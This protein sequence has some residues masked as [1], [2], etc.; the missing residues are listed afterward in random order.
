MVEELAEVYLAADSH[1]AVVADDLKH[2]KLG[3]VQTE[4]TNSDF[5]ISSERAVGRSREPAKGEPLQ[6]S[7]PLVQQVLVLSAPF[8]A[9]PPFRFHL[10]LLLW[11]R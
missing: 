8:H 11:T 5:C 3:P 7:S 1:R 4:P 2:R 6:Y 9:A 10:R